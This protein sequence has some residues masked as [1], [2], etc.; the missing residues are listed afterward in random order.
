M[1]QYVR[2]YDEK[3]VL[4]GNWRTALYPY[5]A[6]AT[7]N[8]NINTRKMLRENCP[9]GNGYAFNRFLA[10]LSHTKIIE[11]YTGT[12]SVFDSLSSQINAA[13]F[14]TSYV[15][16]GAHEIWRRGRGTNVL[17]YDGHVKWM[18]QKPAFRAIKPPIPPKAKK[19]SG[20]TAAPR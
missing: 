4:A 2:D 16:N 3:N 7:I 14:G 11:D 9:A 19:K 20:K 17:F 10:G 8:T 5:G 18:Q 1:L 12:P 15:T 13:D 6:I